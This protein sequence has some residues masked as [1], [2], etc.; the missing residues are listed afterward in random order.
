VAKELSHRLAKVGAGTLCIEP[1]SPWENRYCESFNGKL[2][3]ECLN[4]EIFCS[5]KEAKI[6]IEK[7]RVEYNTK[8]PQGD[9]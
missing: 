7:W 3:D 2:R 4:G 1:G 8:W 9:Y 5:L 6:V